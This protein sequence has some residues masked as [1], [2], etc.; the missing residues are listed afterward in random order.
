LAKIKAK[1]VR[2]FGLIRRNHIE[3][4]NKVKS[5]RLRKYLKKQYK[6]HTRL[7]RIRI[8][9]KIFRIKRRCNR[10]LKHRRRYILRF[11]RIIRIKKTIKSKI[12]MK[13]FNF[14]LKRRKIIRRR[15]HCIR[16]YTRANS[17]LNS[18]RER[19]IRQLANTKRR[20]IGVE[21]R[22]RKYCR[23]TNN[24][25]IQKRMTKLN[26]KW[27]KV[28]TKRETKRNKVIAKLTQR[29]SFLEKTCDN[30]HKLAQ[31]FIKKRSFLKNLQFKDIKDCTKSHILILFM[32]NQVKYRIKKKKSCY[33][34]CKC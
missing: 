27:K 4:I 14:N 33:M 17:R 10:V 13:K 3:K 31:P 34:Y 1:W 24:V 7:F 19:K 26:L 5:L 29:I 12:H 32:R 21:K 6:I 30:L 23:F 11:E 15:R 16:R 28:D 20:R 18:F 22:L 25:C 2:Y 8:K 9:R